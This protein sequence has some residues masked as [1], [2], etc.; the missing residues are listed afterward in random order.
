[1]L[2]KSVGNDVA[3]KLDAHAELALERI[4]SFDTDHLARAAPF[5]CGLSGDLFG[6]LEKDSDDFA[7]GYAGA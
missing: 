1:M 5:R 7:F 2:R 3:T 4:S 6:H